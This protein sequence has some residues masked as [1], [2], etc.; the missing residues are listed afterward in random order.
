M[1]NFF[2]L[3]DSS[4]ILKTAGLIG[5]LAIVFAESGLFIG[6]FLP[7]DSLLF[8]AG[9]LASQG[10]VSFWLLFFGSMVAAIIGDSVGYAFGKRVGPKIFNQDN[11]LFFNKKYILKSNDFFKKHGARSLILAR[12]VPALRTFTPILAGVG[13]MDYKTFLTY[14]A[15][16]GILWAGG[17]ST[18]GYVLGS[19]VPNIDHYIYPLVIIIIILS[20][21]PAVISFYRS[22]LK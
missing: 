1:H 10:L 6:F 21:L 19:T 22:R 4:T 2:A 16:G 12:F 7:G 5:I 9:F 15:V 8:T 14:N 20:I 18:L 17:L 3:F 13:T 11:S